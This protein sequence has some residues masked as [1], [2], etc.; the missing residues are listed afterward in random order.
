MKRQQLSIRSSCLVV[1]LAFF[2]AWPASAYRMIQVTNNGRVTAGNAVVC[3][4][5]GGFAHWTGLEV[6]WR[7]NQ[8]NQGNGAVSP[9]RNAVETWNDV[10]PVGY[11]LDYEGTTNAGWAT[12]G[13]NTVLWAVG[14]GCV[15]TCL[16]LTAL[17][18][19]NGQE[20]IESD[21]TFNNNVTWTTNGSQ[22]DRET[23][24]LHELGHSLGIHHSEI[25]GNPRPVM[26]ATYLSSHRNL[27]ND[28]RAA[29]NCSYSRYHA[30]TVAPPTPQ[31]ITGPS[32]DLCVGASE[33]YSTPHVAGA[34][35]Y[36]WEVVNTFFG[37]TTANHNV[38]L[39]GWY[40]QPPGNYSLRVR[41]QNA[42][43]SSSW[44]QAGIIVL[45]NSHPACG[46]CS[47]RYCP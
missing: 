14:N 30:C 4:A 44:R 47:G 43:G 32:R 9:T 8:A 7:L 26:A 31:Y 28:D 6:G 29:L 13:A 3:N 25:V 27:T 22:Y 38:T 33:V 21:I 18:I 41:A 11:V 24:L 12:D 2:T 19:Q 34:E 37:Q 16:A 35:S 1:A 40:F 42:C 20:I 15:G 45:P 46:G 39:N 17:V 36:R 23:V 5:G 10:T